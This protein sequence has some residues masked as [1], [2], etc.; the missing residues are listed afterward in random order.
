MKLPLDQKK[1]LDEIG[2]AWQSDLQDL[3]KRWNQQLDKPVD[4]KTKNAHYILP[5]RYKQDKPPGLWDT[6]Q[7]SSHTN[8]EMPLDRNELLDNTA[9][10][11]LKPD[12]DKRKNGDC[13]VSKE[14]KEDKDNK[15]LANG[16][17]AQRTRYSDNK[18]RL[19]RVDLLD[20]VGV[21][22]K[23]DKK[24]Q[25]AQSVTTYDPKWNIHFRI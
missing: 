3:D 10:F 14:Y 23:P 18:T 11:V 5:C 19:A 13:L 7:R 20:D 17:D 12:M 16:V 21:V 25:S 4:C 22:W 6:L 24:V 2:F 1:L 9:R 8:K 15:V